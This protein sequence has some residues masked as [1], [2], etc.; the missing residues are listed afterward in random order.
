MEKEARAYGCNQA[1]VIL[2][3]SEVSVLSCSQHFC[4]KTGAGFEEH[5]Y[6]L[7]LEPN[8]DFRWLVQSLRMPGERDS[9]RVQEF[10]FLTVQGEVEI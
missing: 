1:E 10:Q 8:S 9:V 7:I 4:R 2:H 3:V 5:L 6:P